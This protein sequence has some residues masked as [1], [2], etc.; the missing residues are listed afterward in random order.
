[1]N[2]RRLRAIEISPTQPYAQFDRIIFFCPF[3]CINII[4][5]LD[6]SI[7]TLIYL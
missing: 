4:S 7:R 3:G 6:I 1:M 2:Q 5:P